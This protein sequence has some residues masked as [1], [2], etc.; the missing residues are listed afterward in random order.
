MDAKTHHDLD[1]ELDPAHVGGGHEVN[2]GDGL[3]G[4]RLARDEVRAEADDI[5][6]AAPE[7]RA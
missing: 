3:S 4:Q 5:E 6:L 7:L 2:L 1:L